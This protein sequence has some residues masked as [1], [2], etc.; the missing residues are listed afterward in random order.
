V[1][2]TS[3]RPLKRA[4]CK[5]HA[6]FSLILDL[7]EQHPNQHVQDQYLVLF[8]SHLQGTRCYSNASLPLDQLGVDHRQ[9]GL[10]VFIV[11]IDVS[12]PIS[13]F[14]NA[15]MQRASSVLVAESAALALAA[16]ILT[17]IQT[18]DAHLLVDSQLLANFI[19]GPDTL[20]HRIGR[21][22]HSPKL[23]KHFFQVP[24]QQSIEFNEITIK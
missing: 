15:S 5:L 8:P 16:S 6:S 14:I 24:P 4:S 13:I 2:H 12:P 9:A 19:N 7:I 22:L 11:N 23:S 17:T 21:S 3:H 1:G 20:I 18:R 10:G